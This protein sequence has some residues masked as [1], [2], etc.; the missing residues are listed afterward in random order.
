[1]KT[2][3]AALGLALVA[4]V[5]HADGN[6]VRGSDFTVIDGDTIRLRDERIRLEGPDAPES[7]RPRCYEEVAAAKAAKEK[8]EALLAN[9]TIVM[10]RNGQD[11]YH[12]TLA[13]LYTTEGTE[14]GELMIQSGLALRWSPGK[15]SWRVRA[16]H[17]C[18]EF[19]E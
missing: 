8:L 5:A 18:P 6:I 3:I 19:T 10:V 7:W 16:Q 13:R 14:I 4:S 17:W 11:R 15:A 1:M 9:Q 12:R 2:L